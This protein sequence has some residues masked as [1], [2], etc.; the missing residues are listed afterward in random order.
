MKLKSAFSLRLKRA[1]RGAQNKEIAHRMGL[2]NSLITYYMEGN[3]PPPDKLI[4]ISRITGCSIHW[5][6]TG[7]GPEDV[8][9]QRVEEI[10][11]SHTIMLV[12]LEG[13]SAKSTSAVMLAV[14]FA[15]RGIRTLLI[16]NFSGDSTSILYAKKVRKYTWEKIA[17]N[18]KF[19]LQGPSGRVFFRTPIQ[20]LDLCS[21]NM[22]HQVILRHERVKSFLPDLSAISREYSIIVMDAA[23]KTNPFNTAEFYLASMLTPVHVLIPTS[24]EDLM[25]IEHT[26]E[27]LQ[28]AQKYVGSASLLGTFLTQ[29]DSAKTKLRRRISQL[30]KL[31]PNKVL[32]TVVRQDAALSKLIGDGEPHLV[33]PKSRAALDYLSL[34]DEVLTALGRE[35]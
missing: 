35:K 26:L 4:E 15:R 17:Q 9:G 27:L 8:T 3:I 29:C 13:G 2:S 21:S 24:G 23:S 11:K 20:K 30:N 33:R 12:N 14:E 32:G 5:L 31:V 34:A 22:R 6:V 10:A 25:P 1:F 28:E 7:E 19:D 16:D 18:Y